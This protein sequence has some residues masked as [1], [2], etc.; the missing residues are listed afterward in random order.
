MRLVVV[1]VLISGCGVGVEGSFD[2]ISFSPTTTIVG[3]ARRHELLERQGAIIPVLQNEQSRTFGVLFTS[4]ALNDDH[5]WRQQPADD[6]DNLRRSLATE[7]GLL[8]DDLPLPRL[9]AG[10]TLEASSDGADRDFT[11]AMTQRLPAE[12]QLE[13]GLGALISVSVRVRELD[14]PP[15]GGHMDLDIELRRDRAAGQPTADVVTGQIILNGRVSFAAERLTVDNFAVAAPVMQC[16]MAVGPQ[17]AGRCR[18]EEPQVVL[19]E[20]GP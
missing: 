12:D 2:G 15:R 10:E 18:E 11:F 16:A 20:T 14:D 6:F 7:D 17:Q 3:L 5:A 19:D 1:A 13:A 9:R 4:A 8:I